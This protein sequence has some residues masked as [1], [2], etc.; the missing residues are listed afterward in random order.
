MS[1]KPFRVVP[2]TGVPWASRFKTE[3]AAWGRLLGMRSLLDTPAN[4]AALLREGWVVREAEVT[5]AQAWA[6]I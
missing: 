1:D 5:S 6:G 4:R 3:E 2:P